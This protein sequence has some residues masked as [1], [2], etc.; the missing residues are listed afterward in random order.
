MIDRIGGPFADV[1]LLVWLGVDVALKATLVCLIALAADRLLGR[2]VLARS[3]LWH[4]CLLALVFLPLAAACFPQW[5]VACLPRDAANVAAPG[6]VPG[7]SERKLGGSEARTFAERKATLAQDRRGRQSSLPRAVAERKP[8]MGQPTDWRRM[9]M[10]ASVVAYLA[11]ACLLLIRLFGSW[12]RATGLMRSG[13]FIDQA[14]WNRTLNDLRQQLGLACRVELRSSPTIGVALGVGW[15]RP[16]ILLPEGLARSA[17]PQVMRAVVLHELAHARRGDYAWNLLLRLTQAIYWPH[18]LIWLSGKA[19]ARVREEACDRVC[20]YWLGD[21][22][23]YRQTLVE[24]A[25][26][27]VRRPAASLGMAIART[28][29]L[30]RRL[31][32]LER[33]R[34]LPRCLLSWPARAGLCC[35]I[36]IAA[37]GLAVL[38]LDRTSSASAEEPGA[39]PSSADEP[40][41]PVERDA[42]ASANRVAQPAGNDATPAETNKPDDDEAEAKSAAAANRPVKVRVAKVRREDFVLKTVQMCS[43]VA[44]RTVQLH[45]RVSGII[46]RRNA[47]LGDRV[48]K[49]DVLAEIDAPEIAEDVLIAQADADEAAAAHAKA[50]AGVLVAEA[51]VAEADAIL[52]QNAIELEA[53][54]G[55]VAHRAKVMERV[56]KLIEQRGVE[57]AL[58]DEKQEE[59][60]EAQ[61]AERALKS[62]RRA[63]EA[64]ISR[65]K[66]EVEAAQAGL[67]VAKLRAQAAQRRLGRIRQHTD[68]LQIRAPID[69]AVTAI[70]ANVGSITAGAGKGEPLFAISSVD[71]L[72]AVVELPERDALRVERGRVAGIR[73]DALP[74]RTFKAKV[75]RMAYAFSPIRTLRT[76]IDLNNHEGLLRP[77]MFGAATI[78]LETHANA[79]TIPNAA[80]FLEEGKGYTVYRVVNGRAVAT[81]VNLLSDHVS[82]FAVLDGLAE[83]DVVI[84]HVIS[85]AYPNIELSKS[86]RALADGVP[87]EIEPDDA[88]ES[89]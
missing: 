28:T 70:G 3:A 64:N 86:F 40:A 37:G 67:Q 89:Q 44:S 8:T 54:A 9:G 49:G 20:V 41:K 16:T 83:G 78:D 77:G 52:V 74:G 6:L 85:G 42:Q 71:T 26:G 62:A 17:T 23:T 59:V 25:A 84:T 31:A 82:T 38:H 79:L 32:Q 68:Y 81:R 69:G 66:A 48:K 21:A 47:E 73:F 27:L 61:A 46:T 65:A 12:L 18:P 10:A 45:S 34:A 53:A 22:A 58:A 57:A 4:A 51:N 35:A 55:K 36:I 43:V 87:V 75:S 60:R 24:L 63:A 76:E 15:R 33:G 1:E 72:R 29:R 5:R 19:I 80:S 14:D 7:G 56:Q 39:K 2:R 13:A 30:E 50:Q 11:G 88:E